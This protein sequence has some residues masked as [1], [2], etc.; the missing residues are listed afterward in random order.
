MQKG[1]AENLVPILEDVL[2]QGAKTWQDL[3]AIG[4]GIGPGN[5]TGIRIS[6]ACARGMALSLGIPAIGVT[7]LDAQAVGQEMPLFSI[8]PARRDTFYVQK[9][10]AQTTP[11]EQLSR[12]DVLTRISNSR[13]VGPADQT[14]FPPAEM[15]VAVAIARLAGQRLETHPRDQRP[16][17]FYVRSA[18][19]APAKDAPPQILD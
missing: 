2:K 3:T 19:A 17:P 1:Q 13:A 15:P 6:V 12:G 16:A 11:V 14:D 5:F 4:V 7:S 9:I 18:D 10:D 8:I